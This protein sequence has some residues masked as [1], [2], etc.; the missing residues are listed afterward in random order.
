MR[1]GGHCDEILVSVTLEIFELVSDIDP[2]TQIV[3]YLFIYLFIYLFG[4]LFGSL[5]N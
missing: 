2:F 5:I 4:L 1:G 3:D